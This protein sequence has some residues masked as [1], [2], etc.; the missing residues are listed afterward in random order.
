MIGRSI[1]PVAA[2]DC[3]LIEAAWDFAAH[4]ADRIERHWQARVA[5]TPALFNGRVLMLHHGSVSG[6]DRDA[7]FE[8]ACFATDF[9]AFMAWR[10]FGFPATPVRN[11]FSMAALETADGAFVL[12]EMAAHTAPAGQIYFPSGTPDGSD[13]RA[14]RVDIEGSAARELAEETGLGSDAVAFLPGLDLVLDP[15]RV[16]C[17]KRVRSDETAEAIVARIHGWLATEENAELAR[18]H[19]VRTA[20]DI[21]PATPDFVADYLR[22]RLESR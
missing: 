3:T 8:G 1:V 17:M 13:V 21:R 6:S 22:D 16:C 7:V 11:I 9:K 4:E 19:I 20:R 14:G 15:I 2:I 12:G 5:E 10:E 18:M